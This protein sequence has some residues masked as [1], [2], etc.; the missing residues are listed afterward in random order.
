MA[1]PTDTPR[2]AA[3]PYPVSSAAARAE[4]SSTPPPMETGEEHDY[5]PLSILAIA[6]LG[7]AIL[8]AVVM[9][10]IACVAFIQQR[11]L[12]LGVWTSVIPIAGAALALVAW[13]Q[14]QRSEGALVGRK[15]ALAGG[16]ICML[17]G[18]V[19]WSYFLATLLAVRQGANA[20]SRAWIDNVAKGN[21]AT[22]YW[23]ILNPGV[24]PNLPANPENDVG[25]RNT[26]EFRFNG[27]GE[28]GVASFSQFCRRDEVH[29]VLQA[30]QDLKVE[31]LGVTSWEYVGTGYVVKQSYRLT[32]PQGT[33]EMEMTIHGDEARRG[34]FVGRQWY[35]EPEQLALDAKTL[36]LTPDGQHALNLSVEARN[37]GD[38]WIG[39]LGNRELESAFLDT[40]PEAEREQLRQTILTRAAA[41]NCMLLASTPCNPGYGSWLSL[42]AAA[43]S[44]RQLM[45]DTIPGFKEFAEGGLVHADRD[46]FWVPLDGRKPDEPDFK[47]SF[48]KKQDDVVKEAKAFFAHPK[49]DFA[50]YIEW[51]RGAHMHVTRRENGMFAVALEISFPLFAMKDPQTVDAHLILE[52]PEADA[53]KVQPTSWRVARIDLQRSKPMAG[54][55]GMRG[56]PKMAMPPTA[57]SPPRGPGG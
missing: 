23:Y 44:S 53:P 2:G 9:A 26:L 55:P 32:G 1:D 36:R 37:Y 52:C 3:V 18:L 27:G 21:L 28:A 41:T 51:N 17:V 20:V 15:L 49:A 38:G 34:E 7:V 13:L 45:C 14:I 33:V 22:A 8:Y 35:I 50:Q 39:K 19:Y 25:F 54:P 47:E 6:A 10:I 42:R 57:P 30:G 11:P 40:V 56:R 4:T 12:I 46:R 48:A 31:P 29:F 43:L 16:A 24:R 5:H